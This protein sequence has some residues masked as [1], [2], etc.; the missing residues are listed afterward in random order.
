MI[1]VILITGGSRDLGFGEVRLNVDLAFIS[2]IFG[3]VCGCVSVCLYRFQGSVY[4]GVG[5]S[6]FRVTGRVF[7]RHG[8]LN[9]ELLGF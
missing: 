1:V 6:N 9:C 4:E 3:D 7:S 5:K 2:L 8:L